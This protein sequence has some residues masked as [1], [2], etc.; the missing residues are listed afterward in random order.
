MR[1]PSEREMFIVLT[2]NIQ[3][4]GVWKTFR[5]AIARALGTRVKALWPPDHGVVDP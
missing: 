2:G 5:I 3:L 1:A 4:I